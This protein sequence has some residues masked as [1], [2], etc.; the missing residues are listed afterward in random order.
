MVRNDEKSCKG[1]KTMSSRVSC[2]AMFF[3]A[4][5]GPAKW[6]AAQSHTYNVLCLNHGHR[7]FFFFFF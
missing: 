5:V 2:C 7:F 1:D 3:L 4:G 6:H